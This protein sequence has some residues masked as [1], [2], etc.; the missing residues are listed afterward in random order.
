MPIIITA[1]ILILLVLLITNIRIVPQATVYVVERLGAYYATWETGLHFKI[2]MI[3][4]IAKKISLKEQ[5]MDFAPP[6]RHHQ[7]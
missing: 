3:D 4:R 5:V 6:A 1:L 2:P 7:G